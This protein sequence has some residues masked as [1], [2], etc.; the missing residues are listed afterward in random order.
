ML[1]A[2]PVFLDLGS[3]GVSMNTQFVGRE[4]DIPPHLI[5]TEADVVSFDLTE[6]S[7]AGRRRN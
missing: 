1:S 6:Q 7:D 3:Q 2:E 5:Q 4:T